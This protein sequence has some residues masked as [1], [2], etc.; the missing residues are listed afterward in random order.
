MEWVLF[1]RCIT[2]LLGRARAAMGAREV[3]MT[4]EEE[5]QA[6]RE[7]NSQLKATLLRDYELY[8]AEVEAMNAQLKQL[9][10]ESPER[11]SRTE[12]VLEL[13]MDRLNGR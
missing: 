6:L 12:R 13:A 1:I 4:S 10:A 5:I 2:A 9:N 7:E 11:R 3:Q 8:R